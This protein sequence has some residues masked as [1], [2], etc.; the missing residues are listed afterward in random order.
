MFLVRVLDYQI[1]ILMLMAGLVIDIGLIL[2]YIAVWRRRRAEAQSPQ[3]AT[4][5]LSWI[6]SLTWFVIFTNVLIVGIGI[7][8]T[9]Y[10]ILY[11]PNW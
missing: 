5:W 6:G 1:V 11:P 4:G 7:A 10:R 3:G 9:V 8:Y 2:G